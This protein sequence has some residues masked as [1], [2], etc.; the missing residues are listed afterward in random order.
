MDPCEGTSTDDFSSPFDDSDLS[1]TCLVCGHKPARNYYGSIAC[2]RCKTFFLRVAT[3]KKRYN[4]EYNSNCKYP[5][6]RC[7]ACRYHKCLTVGLI[8]EMAGRRE[9]CQRRA[10]EGTMSIIEPP[11]PGLPSLTEEATRMVAVV[12]PSTFKTEINLSIEET[13]QILHRLEEI[14]ARDDPAISLQHDFDFNLNLSFADVLKNPTFIC[15]R[16]PAGFSAASDFNPFGNR[17]GARCFARMVVY[18]ADWLRATPEIWEMKEID[19]LRF[20]LHTCG[21]LIPIQLYYYTYKEGYDGMLQ[22]LGTH[23]SCESTLGAGIPDFLRYTTHQFHNDISPMLKKVKFSDDEFVVW[24][25]MI[26]FNS[27]L[28]LSDES[29][30]IVRKARNRYQGILVQLLRKTCTEAEAIA[31]MD[32]LMRV[33]RWLE[34]NATQAAVFFAKIFAMGGGGAGLEAPLVGDVFLARV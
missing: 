23:F 1:L 7:P 18:C 6:D 5:K 3:R 31:K 12:C 21:V 24:K 11:S 16:V 9:G 14:C 17:M 13:I 20:C 28:G 32:V 22:G 34:N 8:P 15:P 33:H 2:N 4:C 10:R 27:T 25:N 30:T 19:R 26:I 29:A